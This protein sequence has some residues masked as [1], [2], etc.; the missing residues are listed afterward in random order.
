[1]FNSRTL[2]RPRTVNN[3]GVEGMGGVILVVE[4][5]CGKYKRVEVKCF[6]VGRTRQS[7]RLVR[8]LHTER[9]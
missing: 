8:D 5:L 9:P 2:T 1:M 3:E 7:D 6:I 4:N